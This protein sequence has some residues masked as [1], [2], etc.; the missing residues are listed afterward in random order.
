MA[1]ITVLEEYA[2]EVKTVGEDDIKDA[3]SRMIGEM[4]T[5][6]Q[7]VNIGTVSKALLGPGGELESKPVEKA[8]LAKAI[9]GML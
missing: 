1:Q 7:Q 6:G 5:D 9:K 2:S 4:R 3:V 8:E